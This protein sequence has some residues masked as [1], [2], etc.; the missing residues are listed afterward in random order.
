MEE[1]Y[2]PENLKKWERVEY[3]GGIDLSKFYCTVGITRDSTEL[4]KSNFNYILKQVKA[5]GFDITME[6]EQDDD[7]LNEC[8][9]LA[10][11]GHWGVGWIQE[12]LIHESNVKA[13]EFFD[14]IL[15][16]LND[17]PILDEVDYAQRE[18]QLILDFIRDGIY[19]I[20]HHYYNDYTDNLDNDEI[21]KIT[22]KIY[23]E[24]PSE[25]E[26]DYENDNIHP[27]DRELLHTLVT[28]YLKEYQV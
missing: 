18:R 5:G 8:L 11:F 6:Y 10:H 3:Y 15:G 17:Y 14:E 25:F 28:K 7:K 23:N 26:I 21:E 16:R 22:E 13:L 24:I 12:V 20:Y 19:Q 27:L 2:I 4:E 9:L 1:K